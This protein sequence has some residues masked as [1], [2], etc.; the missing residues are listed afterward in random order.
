VEE[1]VNVTRDFLFFN[2][3]N[4]MDLL[5]SYDGSQLK[6]KIQFMGCKL[7][8]KIAM[9]IDHQSLQV[10]KCCRYVRRASHVDR[11]AEAGSRGFDSAEG[12][13]LL[14]RKVPPH[15]GTRIYDVMA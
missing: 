1:I 12:G 7:V 3:E 4:G 2:M 15:P 8:R 9:N 13:R 11:R 6:W 14:C 10:D 5:E